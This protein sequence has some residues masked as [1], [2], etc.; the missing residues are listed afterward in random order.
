MWVIIQCIEWKCIFIF[1]KGSLDKTLLRSVNFAACVLLS[2]RC[3]VLC[4]VS[5]FMLN[6][7]IRV[8]NCCIVTCDFNL[9]L[10]TFF[11]MFFYVCGICRHFGV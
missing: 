10:I 8:Y 11:F 3:P 6:V 2:Y 7:G 1:R 5:S 9:T 4:I